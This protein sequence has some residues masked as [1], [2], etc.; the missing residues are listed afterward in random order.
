MMSR[1][2]VLMLFGRTGLRPSGTKIKN[3]NGG[4]LS[5]SHVALSSLQP[6]C[7]L[8]NH[9]LPYPMPINI[10]PIPQHP[11]LIRQQTSLDRMRIA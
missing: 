3:L 10:L 11:V 2:M 6:L 5:Q 9:H 4:G 8:A 7:R 1:V